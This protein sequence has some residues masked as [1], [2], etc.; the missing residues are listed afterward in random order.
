[1]RGETQGPSRPVWLSTRGAQS[2]GERGRGHGAAGPERP[3]TAWSPRGRNGGG[4]K[5]RAQH[6][7]EASPSPC[8]GGVPQLREAAAGEGGGLNL[9]QRP[10]EPGCS[11]RARGDGGGGVGAHRPRHTA[12]RPLRAALRPPRPCHQTGQSLGADR[13]GSRPGLAKP[14]PRGRLKKSPDGHFNDLQF[15]L[16]P[17]DSPST[18]SAHGAWD[19]QASIPP[20][21]RPEPDGDARQPCNATTENTPVS[22]ASSDRQRGFSPPGTTGGWGGDRSGTERNVPDRKSTR[23][24][25]SH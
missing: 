6:S 3:R 1:M 2:P 15:T 8:R 16:L 11:A 13:V 19:R 12:R 4:E 22:G 7:R 14:Q 20:H 10:S 9:Q 24:N 17:E 25:S 23:L 5:G 18:W 21:T